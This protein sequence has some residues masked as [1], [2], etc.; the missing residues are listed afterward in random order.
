MS[1]LNFAFFGL[2]FNSL[3]L[4]LAVRKHDAKKASKKKSSMY[5]IKPG[6]K[7]N[8]HVEYSRFKPYE[9]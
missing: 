5:L 3:L 6:K 2:K 7:E 8:Q 4:I 9:G 1:H